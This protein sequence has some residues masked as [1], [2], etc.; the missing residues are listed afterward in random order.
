VLAWNAAAAEILTDFG[1]LAEADRNILLYMFTDPDA[2]RLFGAT[3]SDEARR[4]VAQFRA[5]F[6]LWAGDAAFLDLFARLRRGSSQFAALWREHEIRGPAVGQKLLH[7]RK[8][9][10]LRFE[11]ATFQA[12]DDAA[13]K[14]AIYAPA[15]L[16]SGT[17]Q[18]FPARVRSQASDGP[19]RR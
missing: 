3:W 12:N 7:H 19:P 5:T 11:Y 18:G 16:N 17:R 10:A 15:R 2:R 4:M 13:L 8:K 14:L 6:D 1:L 9:G